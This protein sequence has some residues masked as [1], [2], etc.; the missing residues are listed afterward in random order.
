MDRGFLGSFTINPEARAAVYLRSGFVCEECHEN[1][2]VHVHHLT[3][4]R[5][6]HELPEDLEHVCIACHCAAHPRKAAGILAW[7]L[8][9]QGRMAEA[10]GIAVEETDEEWLELE[11]E[12]EDKRWEREYRQRHEREY[13]QRAWNL[14]NYTA[15]GYCIEEVE[16]EE[17]RRSGA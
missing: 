16:A 15:S 17:L 4:E 11:Q 3:Y 9:R 12:N 13:E 14:G 10:E 7:E 2:A 5:A 6:G 8:S 1:Y